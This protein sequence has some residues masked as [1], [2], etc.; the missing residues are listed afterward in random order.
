MASSSRGD[1]LAVVGCA[2]FL[3]AIG[4]GCQSMSDALVTKG[5][6]ARRR[7]DAEAELKFVEAHCDVG[8]LVGE[9]RGF[10]FAL[11]AKRSELDSLQVQ[12]GTSTYRKLQQEL[13]G[14]SVEW[15]TLHG[16]LVRACRDHAVLLHRSRDP[17][18]VSD[19]QLE[20]ARATYDRQLAAAREFVVKIQELNLTQ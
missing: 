9:T 11:D 3:A 17:G 16:D 15:E 13:A 1:R 10:Q 6:D 14:Y 12:L 8:A 4:V 19:E 5:S 20:R 2:A 18:V 7:A